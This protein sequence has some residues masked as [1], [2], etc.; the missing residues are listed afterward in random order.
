MPGDQHK[1]VPT[2]VAACHSR[3]DE[4]EA[5]HYKAW[6]NSITRCEN[7]QVMVIGSTGLL[8]MAGDRKYHCF[9]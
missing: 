4:G 6:A 2:A 5:T 7:G 8:H 1:P 9:H 3:M